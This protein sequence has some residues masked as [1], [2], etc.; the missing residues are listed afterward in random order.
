MVLFFKFNECHTIC[1]GTWRKLGEHR[2]Y[3]V[4]TQFKRSFYYPH[5]FPHT[6]SHRIL[7]H[8]RG[9]TCLTV[10]RL[11]SLALTTQL[12]TAAHWTPL[13]TLRLPVHLILLPRLLEDHLLM[14][15]TLRRF[16]TEPLANKP[17]HTLFLTHSMACQSSPA[18]SRLT[19]L[20]DTLR[21][22]LDHCRTLTP[23]F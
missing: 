14:C 18:I 22:C 11:L 23:P 13:T 17:F 10:F 15:R 16:I 20:W 12:G 5:Y 6:W 19:N 9:V 4:G 7:T 8:Q 21:H 3:K 1:L 2:D